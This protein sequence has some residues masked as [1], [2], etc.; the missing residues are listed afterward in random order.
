M[1]RILTVIVVVLLLASLAANSYWFVRYRRQAEMMSAETHYAFQQHR[2][3]KAMRVLQLMAESNPEQ[4]LKESEA[5][6]FYSVE[7]ITGIVDRL[8]RGSSSYSVLWQILQKL[9]ADLAKHP[10]RY[11]ETN[12]L[13]QRIQVLRQHHL[14]GQ[15]ANKSVEPTAALRAAVAHLRR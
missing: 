4:L 2:L 14:Q 7:G 10:L 5:D 15:V 13:L 1:R 6:L 11:K 9:E 8:D 3:L 12:E